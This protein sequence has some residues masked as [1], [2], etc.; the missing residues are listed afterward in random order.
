MQVKLTLVVGMMVMHGLGA[1]WRKRLITDPHFKSHKFFRVMNEV[2]TLL[3]IGIV[4][5]IIV[6]P[7]FR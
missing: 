4:I 7:Y 6:R 5:M 3:M 1:R 2:P